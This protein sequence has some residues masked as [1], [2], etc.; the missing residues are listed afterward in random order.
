MTIEK[1]I[2]PFSKN[3]KPIERRL[4]PVQPPHGTQEDQSRYHQAW[5]VFVKN[6]RVVWNVYMW[7]LFLHLEPI[8]L[9]PRKLT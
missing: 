4:F 8:N 6:I 1:G 3:H 5:E 7:I 9:H 2:H